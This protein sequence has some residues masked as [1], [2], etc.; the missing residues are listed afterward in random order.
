MKSTI[1]ISISS[2]AFNMEHD[3]YGCLKNYL[4]H[5]E[6]TFSGKDGGGEIIEDIEVRIAELLSARIQSPAQSITLAMVSEVLGTVG[7]VDD[8]AGGEEE[9]ATGAQEQ[10]KAPEPER[11][12]LF[13][14]IDHRVIGGVCSGLGNYFGIDRVFIRLVFAIALVNGLFF[15]HSFFLHSFFG[16][17]ALFMLLLYIILWIATPAA[18]TMKEKM[19][20]RKEKITSAS[21]NRQEEIPAHAAHEGDFGRVLGKIIVIFFRIIAGFILA[22]MAFTALGLLIGLPIG[23]VTGNLALGELGML[24]ISE[25]LRNYT[26]IPVW[27][28]VVL[29]TLLICLPLVGLIYLLAKVCF[30]F[31]TKLRLGLIMTVAWLVSLFSLAAIGIYIASDDEHFPEGLTSEVPGYYVED[32]RDFLPFKNLGIAGLIEVTAFSSDSNYMIIHAPERLLSSVRVKISDGDMKIYMEKVQ[33]LHKK[34]CIDFYYSDWKN[35]EQLRMSGTT[36]F[37]C[38]DT[39]RAETFSAKLSGASALDIIV[40]NKY[41]KLEI[42]GAAK[43]NADIATEKMIV[44]LSGAGMVTLSGGASRADVNL[45]G[46]TKLNAGGFVADTAQIKLS[47]SSKAAIHANDYLNARATGASHIEYSGTPAAEIS[48]SGAAKIRCSQ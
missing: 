45:S 40:R 47:G 37:T 2:I 39:L 27:L 8:I 32:K 35:L 21:S 46:V 18:R 26:V 42:S 19:V 11:K 34:V 41:S 15:T 44:Q 7:S 22:I 23:F 24:D 48:A 28:V 25:Y 3:A 13:R 33:R 10:F 12:R 30:K 14:D 36:R 38:S 4:D 5:V 43:I 31:K 20:M 6:N 9:T 17:I 1:K 29:L 16:R